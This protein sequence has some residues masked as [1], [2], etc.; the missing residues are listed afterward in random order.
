[1]SDKGE[2]TCI[3]S[4]ETAISIAVMNA[5]LNSRNNINLKKTDVFEYLDNCISRGEKFEW[6]VL[7]PP[8]FVKNKKKLNEAVKGY[9]NLNIKAM[10][11]MNPGAI[12][13]TSSCSG[14]L[15]EDVFIKILK[16]SAREAKKDIRII[17]NGCQAKD[18][19]VIPYMPESKYLKCIFLQIF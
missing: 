18:H 5:S 15:R 1:M 4:S 2:V 8:A 7:D 12:L 9:K 10:K 3:D 14:N 17:F 19:P 13:I 6:I 11:L 16:D